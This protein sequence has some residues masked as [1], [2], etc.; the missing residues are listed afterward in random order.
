MSGRGT[1]VIGLGATGFSCI[2]HLCGRRSASERLFA[3][4]TRPAPPFADAVRDGFGEVEILAPDD[5]GR[6]LGDAERAVVSPGLALDHCLV[7][8]ARRAGLALT[9]DIELFLAAADA[10]VVG[11]TGTNG[12]STVTALVAELLAASGLKAPAG[13]NLGTPALDLLDADADAYVLEL[14]SFQLERLDTPGL[15]VAALLNITPDHQDRY[16]DAAAYVE[17]KRRIYRGAR[18]AVYNA[19]DRLTVPDA[20]FAGRRI[21]LNADPAWALDT[22]LIVGGERVSATEIGLQG[23]HNHFNALAAVAVAHQFANVSLPNSRRALRA[24]LSG[25][26]PHRS[27]FVAEAAGVRFIDDSKATNV[28]ATIAALDGFGTG[29]RNIV[30]IAGGDAKGASF[31]A[32][33]AA[34][35]R[36]VS[37]VVLIGRDA[38]AVAQALRGS[39]ALHRAD[40]MRHA[41]RLAG[42]RACAGQTVLLSPACASFDMY[43][44]FAARGDDFANAVREWAAAGAKDGAI[45]SGRAERAP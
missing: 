5:F 38:D 27:A 26:L 30:L 40:D 21:A 20:E 23:R 2:R 4:D 33:A 44:S 32:L 25:G 36:H 43:E 7:R 31:R 34:V 14:S 28:G 37:D 10:P 6:A 24:A 35:A 18:C 17:A 41:V 9:S 45:A 1:I 15:A 16:A 13:G 39:A 11:I 42:G 8:A 19:D 29:E 3:V 22:D 12:K